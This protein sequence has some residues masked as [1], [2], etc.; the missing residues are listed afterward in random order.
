M[1]VCLCYQ[2]QNKALAVSPFLQADKSVIFGN[3]RRL[4][5]SWRTICRLFRILIGVRGLVPT[6]AR[7]KTIIC[8]F[9]GFDV[10]LIATIERLTLDCYFSN[11]YCSRPARPR[12]ILRFKSGR[13]LWQR[14]DERTR[15]GNM[16][17]SLP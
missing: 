7:T 1:S 9:R 2:I 11:P 4:Q 14:C 10:G 6:P 12:E 3:P 13:T 17:K 8:C 15:K 5:T 16:M